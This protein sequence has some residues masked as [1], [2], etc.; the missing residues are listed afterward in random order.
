MQLFQSLAYPTDANE[1]LRPLHC[2]AAA[3]SRD[4]HGVPAAAE[5]GRRRWFTAA[6]R[7]QPI[8]RLKKIT[9]R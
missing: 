7:A 9:N 8:P 2:F 4:S 3:V 5:R 1:W 6:G